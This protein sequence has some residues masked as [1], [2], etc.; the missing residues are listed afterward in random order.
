M[1]L[2]I[3]LIIAGVALEL[4]GIGI[5]ACEIRKDM[6]GLR[7]LLKG[8][9]GRF[10]VTKTLVT[11]FEREGEPPPPEVRINGLEEKVVE[12]VTSMANSAPSSRARSQNVSARS[13]SG[14]TTSSLGASPYDGWASACLR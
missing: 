14:W 10:K 12:L 4:I 11:P 13:L 6:R 8:E 5:T 3:A 7:K 1:S 2:R 9:A